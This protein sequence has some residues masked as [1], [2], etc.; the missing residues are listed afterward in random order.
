MKPRSEVDNQVL[1]NNLCLPYLQLAGHLC[2]ACRAIV[3]AIDFVSP[4][5]LLTHES[6]YTYLGT[7]V[8]VRYSM[9][10]EGTLCILTLYLMPTT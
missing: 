8:K 5:D 1:L 4:H 6:M 9:H 3:F 10:T 2:S 7:L